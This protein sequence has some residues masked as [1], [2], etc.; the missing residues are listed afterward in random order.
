M[1]GFFFFLGM[2]SHVTFDDAQPLTFDSKN[3]TRPSQGNVSTM[4]NPVLGDNHLKNVFNIGISGLMKS[5][6]VIV[7][8]IIDMCI[9]L[10]NFGME[11]NWSLNFILFMLIVCSLYPILRILGIIVPNGFVMNFFERLVSRWKKSKFP[12]KVKKKKGYLNNEERDN[13][14]ELFNE[15]VSRKIK[16]TKVKDKK[17]YNI[18]GFKIRRRPV[19]IVSLI[20]VLLIIRVGFIY[21]GY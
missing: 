21:F 19:M 18:M 17:T 9:E 13:L 11:F 1:L 2:L 14:H 12:I 16:E 8:V 6:F 3:I 7:D 4:A 15:I 5:A 10:F 20:I